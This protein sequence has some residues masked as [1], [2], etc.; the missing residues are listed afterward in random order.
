M[1]EGYKAY[2]EGMQAEIFIMDP[3]NENPVLTEVM[4]NVEPTVFL[5]SENG[6]KFENTQ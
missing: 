2:D 5:I 6:L 4:M 1:E 3:N